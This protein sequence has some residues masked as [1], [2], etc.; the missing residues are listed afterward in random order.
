M[1]TFTFFQY[2][3]YLIARI[4][5]DLIAYTMLA[6]FC[7]YTARCKYRL[8]YLLGTSALFH[9]AVLGHV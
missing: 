5:M 2:V 7:I 1:H 9:E 4:H 8:I 6:K 3:I